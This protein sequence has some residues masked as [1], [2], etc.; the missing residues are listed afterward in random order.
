MLNLIK[1]LFLVTLT[2]TALAQS[3]NVTAKSWAV[4]D[5]KGRIIDGDK[6]DSIRPIASITKVM[7]AMIVLDA[8]QDL[9]EYIKPYTRRELI[10]LAMIRSDN[11]A[12]LTLCDRYPGGRKAC[13]AAMNA[14]AEQLGMKDTRFVEASGLRAENVST[15]KDLIK[16]AIAAQH[17]PEI[18]Q[19]SKL[20][21]IRISVSKK[22]WL[23]FNNTNPIIGKRHDILVSKTG[24]IRA[25]GGC[26][27]M[28]LD[29]DIGT[30]VVIVLNSDSTRTRIPEA[31]FL[32][33]YVRDDDQQLSWPMGL[34]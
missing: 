26:L 19:A 21:H 25:S 11:Q 34:Y 27:L 30:R 6:V 9:N 17:Y 24:W 10:Q 31:E 7:T 12:S 13:H 5:G 1:I 20:P 29:T 15:A 16:M 23:I 28:L 8:Q 22:K 3:F 14:K 18:V 4:A 32:L 2:S 33:E